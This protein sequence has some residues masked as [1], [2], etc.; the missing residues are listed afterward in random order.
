[1]FAPPLKVPK[2][3]AASQ[4]API[5][6]PKPPHHVPRWSGGSLSNIAAY[7]PERSSRPEASFPLV[8]P[9]LAVG[10]V[11]DP[12]EHEADRVADQ[13]MRMPVPRAS[14][15]A[16]SP[17]CSRE[18]EAPTQMRQ[19][20]PSP[21]L[22]HKVLHTPG[23]PL[24]AAMR[25]YF[26]PRFRRDFSL[27]RVHTDEAAAR[28]AQAVDARAYTVGRDLVFGP[29]TYQ[30]ATESGR[31]LIAHELTHAVQQTQGSA[32][33]TPPG[34]SIS[35][36]QLARTPGPLQRELIQPEPVDINEP[37]NQM[38]LK[39]GKKAELEFHSTV[40]FNSTLSGFN[41]TAPPKEGELSIIRC[42]VWNTGWKSA[43][44]H[45][46]RL[47][48]YK[49][50]ICSGCRN[51]KDEIYRADIPAPS[52]VSINQ[53]GTSDYESV[54]M[55]GMSLEAGRYDVYLELDVRDEVEEINEDNNTAFMV[56]EVNPE[57]GRAERN[58][59]P[60]ED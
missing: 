25:A 26:E 28:S 47:T 54:F 45:T 4:T 56:F 46:N 37:K 6:A 53:A 1:M 2:P 55:V 42:A 16:G 17:Q 24:D 15:T 31:R 34:I 14:L 9:K 57:E 23:Q 35:S 39:E 41:P 43:P 52:V 18:F 19:T 10:Q 3:K 21:G 49:A 58:N 36:V 33:A 30:P 29:G 40:N 8:Q 38:P 50:D 13:V 32:V 7:A 27:I 5:R 12:L 51:E 60:G 44:E 22:L 48:I 11:K 59:D 20:N